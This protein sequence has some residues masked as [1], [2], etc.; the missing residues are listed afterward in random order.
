MKKLFILFCLTAESV[1]GQNFS[2][3]VNQVQ[4][5]APP[6][7]QAMVD[8]FMQANPVLPLKEN[9]TLAH[10]IITGNFNKVEVAGDMNGW[11]AGQIV[12][13]NIS[14]TNFWYATQ[15]YEPNARLDYK[16]ITNGSNWIL[17]PNNP[18]QVSGGFGPNSELAMPQYVQ[19]WE[20]KAYAG[21][22]KGTVSN[23]SVQS[24]VLNAAHQ[25][26]VYLPPSYDSTKTYPTAYFHDGTEY[27]NLGNA[28]NVLDNLIDSNLIQPLIGVFVKPNNRNEEY[29]MSKRFTY[30]NFFCDEL[31][32][33]ADARFATRKDSSQRAT[34]GAS[35]GGN[36]SALIAFGRPEV[37]FKAGFHSGAF[38][39]NSYEALQL[40]DTS[41]VL[42]LPFASVWGSYEGSLPA[43]WR[44]VRDS[45][46]SHQ[47]PDKYFNEYPEGHSW[48]LWRATL[49]E[50]LIA[51]FPGSASIGFGEHHLKQPWRVY[52]NPVRDDLK[53]EGLKANFVQYSIVGLD[54][55]HYKTGKLSGST[56][57]QLDLQALPE[58]LYLLLLRQNN[59]SRTSHL[60]IKN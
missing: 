52:P 56:D 14:S 1:S 5:S 13:Q 28:A 32:P 42:H 18:H 7:R 41:R 50:I 33:W 46:N 43:V 34:I 8:S 2:S 23:Y 31:V 45:L 15:T 49:D 29:A 44:N 40:I 48:G 59:E 24:S 3:F 17:D 20:I 39:P 55:H 26:W 6:L 58:G 19:P 35:F 9:D 30:R 38:W 27:L 4:T 53:I 21:V 54:G 60:F 10:F 36:I 57:H 47:I 37:F 16:I 11:S 25:V 12:L 22:P 51:L